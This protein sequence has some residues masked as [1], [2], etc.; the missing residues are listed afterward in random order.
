MYLVTASEMQVM[1]RQTIDAYGISS[2]VLM[3][4]AGR[5][6]TRMMMDLFPETA[7][8]RIGIVAGK[9]NNGGDGFVMARYL[10]HWG[11]QP[12]VY[13]LGE[14]SKVKGDAAVNLNLLAP[15]TVPVLEL[16]DETAFNA[17]MTSL[18]RQQ[19]WI[20][21]IL[22]TGL[23]SDVQGYYRKVITFLND[24]RQ[25]I[26]SVDISSGLDSESGRPQGC[27][28]QAAATA[29]FG[30]PKIGQVV[31]PGVD[32]T[33][34]LGVIDIGIPAH[35]REAVAPQQAL[36][37]P[38]AVAAS[39]VPRPPDAHK[40]TAGHLAVLAGSRGKSGAAAMTAMSAMKIGS[41]LVT[42]GTPR[43]LN[44]VLETLLL[45][46]MTVPL[47]EA[48]GGVLAAAGASQLDTLL[49]GKTA[50][51]LGPGMGTA[52][53][54]RQLL[55]NLLPMIDVPVVIDADGLN[56]LADH[57]E[58]LKAIEAP[59]I[60]TPHPGEMARLTGVSVTDIQHDRIGSARELARRLTV[61]VVLKGARTV[62][63]HPDGTVFVNP[64][65]NAGMASGGMG[66]VLTGIIGGLLAQGYAPDHAAQIG[67]FLH[68]A[69]AD[70]VARDQGRIGYL[71][72]QV[73]EAL[74]LELERLMASGG[75]GCDFP[76]VPEARGL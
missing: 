49:A 36:I 51:A 10:Y 64:T 41:G 9:G 60:I 59:V 25:S 24:T 21:A 1:D 31:Y 15:L 20:D 28:L 7:G 14:A 42:L 65:G 22:G 38:A 35:V 56:L 40:G 13:L 54:T 34:R 11:A 69:A 43:S 63:A 48:D 61:Y 45:E 55:G 52:D 62:V 17:N 8:K 29:T 50:L 33:G 30:F 37:T 73:M 46:V 76:G 75:E 74:P 47:A 5:G 3:E 2:L 18:T 67:V 26:F 44:P 23:T 12:T 53:T 68:G 39:I 58:M 71:A 66:D 72:T 16:P 27:C 19:F 6:A 32:F 4:N 57:P 70:A